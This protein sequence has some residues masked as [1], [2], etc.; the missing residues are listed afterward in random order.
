MDIGV[1]RMKKML[2]NSLKRKTI[3]TG[4]M[5]AIVM[6]L[7]VAL[8]LP[9][10]I[11]ARQAIPLVKSQGNAVKEGFFFNICGEQKDPS[12]V[13]GT[14][15]N[16]A[17]VKRGSEITILFCARST[18]TTAKAWELAARDPVHLGDSPQNGIS[19]IFDSK[20]LQVPAYEGSVDDF[21][22]GKGD[23]LTFNV[24]FGANVTAKTGIQRVVIEARHPTDLGTQV[25]GYVVYLNVQ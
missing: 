20:S 13:K 16:P 24:H 22:K 17:V 14:P 18:D 15:L 5:A 12:N 3:V 7:V 2:R 19:V 6:G 4:L 23:T 11:G 21:A 1:W 10:E 25:L 9:Q 8:V